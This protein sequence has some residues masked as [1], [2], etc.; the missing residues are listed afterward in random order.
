MISYA[1]LILGSTGHLGFGAS[2]RETDLLALGHMDGPVHELVIL[3]HLGLSGHPPPPKVITVIRWKPPQIGWHKVN[4]DGSAPS[5][6]GHI[7]AGA[8]FRNSRSFF[9]SDFAKAM[10][11]G[12]PFKAELVV[13]LHAI[14]FTF[15]HG[16]HSLW[17][18]S[19]STL[20]IQAIHENIS[21]IPW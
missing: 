13:V 16:W 17:V 1:P 4:V 11:W 8:V 5:S 2:I 19:D 3:G 21:I 14:L 18:E 9:V 15:E 6:P 10:G 12:Y 7:F 20:A